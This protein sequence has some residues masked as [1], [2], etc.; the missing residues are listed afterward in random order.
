MY[1]DITQ[2]LLRTHSSI[3]HKK[4][5]LLAKSTGEERGC[6][7]TKNDRGC[8]PANIVKVSCTWGNIY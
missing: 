6:C 5:F 3:A 8:N 7:E 1:R 4:S 2:P